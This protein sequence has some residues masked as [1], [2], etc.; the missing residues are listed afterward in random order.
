MP[1]PSL[2]RVNQ[3]LAQA[4]T[5]LD[6]VDD[7]AITPIHLDSLKEAATF[8]LVCAYHHYLREIAETYWLKNSANIRTENDLINAFHA[9]KKQPAEA[10]ELISLRQDANSWLGQLYTSYESLWLVPAVVA[11]EPESDDLLIKTINLESNFDI[12]RVNLALISFWHES[13]IALVLRQR[14]TSVEF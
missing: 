11:R 7:A 8:H 3:K 14:E 2:T 4:K 5:L 10:E 6:C 13:F 1:N 12:A 9:A